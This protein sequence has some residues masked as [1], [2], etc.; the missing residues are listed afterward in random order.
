MP[1]ASS[2]QTIKF[3]NENTRDR[4]KGMIEEKWRARTLGE[5]KVQGTRNETR[6]QLVVESCTHKRGRGQ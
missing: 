2:P 3:E 5:K 1:P 6:R 4:E